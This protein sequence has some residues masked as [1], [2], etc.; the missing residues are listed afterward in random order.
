MKDGLT[1]INSQPLI[2]P[3]KIQDKTLDQLTLPERSDLLREAYGHIEDKETTDEEMEIIGRMETAVD[4]KIASWGMIIK[5]NQEAKEL[6]NIEVEYFKKKL[7][8]ANVRKDR[9]E[10]KEKSL[11]DYLKVK[12]IEFNKK[13]I[14][15][16]LITVSLRKKPQSVVILDE[17]DINNPENVLFTQVTVSN[18]W[19]KKAIKERLETGQLFKSV[20]LSEPDFTISIKGK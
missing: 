15:T 7:A 14:E 19:D 8:E 5:K 10:K 3:E 17:A 4:S 20:K 9:F 11:G 2:A 16:P 13:K 1:V 18:R 12:M 6:C